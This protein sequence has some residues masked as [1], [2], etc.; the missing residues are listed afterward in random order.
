MSHKPT[1]EEKIGQHEFAMSL[2]PYVSQADIVE[3]LR[4]LADSMSTH[5]ALAK[6][7][8]ISDAYLS[9]VLNGRR[10]PGPAICKFLKVE[11]VTVYREVK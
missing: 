1:T 11:A 7:I 6:K 4:L 3:E 2:K 5:R 8:G 9:D 10:D